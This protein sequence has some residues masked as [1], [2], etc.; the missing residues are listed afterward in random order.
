VHVRAPD[1]TVIDTIGAGDAFGAALLA[2]LNDRNMIGPVLQLDKP[3]LESIVG[4]ACSVSALCCRRAGADSPR[5]E[6]L[7][8]VAQ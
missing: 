4:F 6:D 2:W 8:E 1:V 7:I 3:Q 5:L